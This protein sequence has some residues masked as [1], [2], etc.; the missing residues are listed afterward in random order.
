MLANGETKKTRLDAQRIGFDTP[1]HSDDVFNLGLCSQARMNIGWLVRDL[2]KNN[3]DDEGRA[4]AAMAAL[5]TVLAGPPPDAVAPDAPV[6]KRPS[7]QPLANH[8]IWTVSKAGETVYQT[9]EIP[10]TL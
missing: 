2:A 5:G 7:L 4:Q 10:K 9:G 3:L 8:A 1:V 6:R